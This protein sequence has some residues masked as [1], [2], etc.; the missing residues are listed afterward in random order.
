MNEF[1][2]NAKF[3]LVIGEPPKNS[4]REPNLE[5]WKDFLGCVPQFARPNKETKMIHENV[6]LIPLDSGMR[7]LAQLFDLANGKNIPLR[8]LF[9]DEEP[10]WLQYPKL[11]EANL[12]SA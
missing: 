12:V 5:K 2:K 3:A 8:I 1:S 10:D 9:L 11:D 4:F 6:W 7:F